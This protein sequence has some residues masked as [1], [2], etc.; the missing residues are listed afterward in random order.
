MGERGLFRG[1][2][3]NAIDA[4]GRVAIPASIR[5]TIEANSSEPSVVIGK[6]ARLPCL[7]GYDNGWAALL[8]AQIDRNE[9]RALDNG[10][11]FDSDGLTRSAFALTEDAGFDSSGRFVL[12]PFLRSKATL[13][14]WALFLGTGNM[15][16]IWS[17]HILIETPDVAD[18]FK[19]LARYLLAERKVKL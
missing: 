18:D 12:P 17:P 4:K 7:V 19:D 5:K 13:T 6:H 8:N 11:D 3:L 16:E 9:A 2:A 1:H 15:F 14:H 10:R